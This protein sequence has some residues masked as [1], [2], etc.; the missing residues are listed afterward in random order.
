MPPSYVKPLDGSRFWLGDETFWTAL[1]VTG[2]WHLRGKAAYSEKLTY[3]RQG[4]DW[5]NEPNPDLIVTARRL[6]QPA[7]TVSAEQ[8]HP[9]MAKE[10]IMTVI[11]IPSAGC[12]E[13]S[14]RFHGKKLDYI[15]SV[16]P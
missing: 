13:I 4:F 9:I 11:N 1:D 6:D 7:A 3:W 2:I 14:A 5:R 16:E 15:V 12:W 8:A 10:A